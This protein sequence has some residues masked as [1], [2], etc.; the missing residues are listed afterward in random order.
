MWPHPEGYGNCDENDDKIKVKEL[1]CGRTPKGTETAAAVLIVIG[2]VGF[3]VAAP[4][5][6]RK[7][8]ITSSMKPRR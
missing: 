8:A 6:V 3:N 4:R 2:I 5:R 7:L 1:Q